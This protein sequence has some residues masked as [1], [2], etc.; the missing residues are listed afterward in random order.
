M[1]VA[2]ITLEYSVGSD[3]GEASV[4]RFAMALE[5]AGDELKDFGRYVFPRV[6][7]VLEEAEQAQFAARGK[8]P[9]VGAWKP[10]SVRYAKWKAV[11]YP[12]KP[13]LE[14]SG[15]MKEGLTS[16]SSTYA[17]RDYSASMMNFGTVGVPYASYHQIGTPFLPARSPFDFGPEFEVE[18]SK[19]VRLGAIDAVRAAGLELEGE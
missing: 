3:K 7:S 11:H 15:A 1:S 13:L 4:Q 10:L 6:Q 16:T 14:A 18:L 2:A 9:A 8:G 19:A 17:A 12:G 5:R